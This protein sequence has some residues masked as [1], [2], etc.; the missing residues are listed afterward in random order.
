MRNAAAKAVWPLCETPPRATS[1]AP[2][3]VSRTEN[4]AISARHGLTV[5]PTISVTLPP[6]TWRRNR[7]C[8]H[9]H[10][11]ATLSKPDRL[12]LI[13][14]KTGPRHVLLG[15]AA[16]TLLASVADSPFGEWVFQGESG[17]EPLTDGALYWF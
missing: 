4:T 10:D 16:R 6:S 14:A 2:V 8:L 11:K 5:Y 3:G 12:A 1:M 15:G 9:N 17:D 13:D 7:Q